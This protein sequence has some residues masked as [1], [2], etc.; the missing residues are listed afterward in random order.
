LLA[1]GHEVVGV[2]NLNPAYDPRL[3][4]W[5]LEQLRGQPGF[6]FAVC[7]IGERDAAVAALETLGAKPPLD[8]VFN[9]A[10]RA[11]VRASVE[12]PW[13]YYDANVVGTINMLELCRAWGVPKFVVASSSSV[14][15]DSTAVPY[16][17]DQPVNRPISPYAASKEAAETISY[18]YHH[19]HGIDVSALRYFTVY[20]PAG[21]PDMSVFRFVRAIAEGT[22]LTLFG[23]GTQQRDFTYVDDI[24]RG[25]IAALAPVGY[26]VFNLGSDQPHSVQAMLEL[27]SK[28]IGKVPII[29]RQLAHAADVPQTWADIAKAKR[30][31]NWK[32]QVSFEE[33]LAACV[34]WYREHWAFAST[35]D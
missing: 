20:G 10:A 16:R 12:D 9:L 26:E 17:E 27:L 22:P 14:Y 2:D 21:R 34:A 32:P 3:K 19:L 35:L 5:R 4:H 7:D 18:T 13:A 8:A 30:L 25:T 31:L 28:L 23:D 11:G 15:G 33:G 24:A 1:A 6:R 29:E